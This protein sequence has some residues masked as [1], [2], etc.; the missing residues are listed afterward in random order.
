VLGGLCG[1]SSFIAGPGH[2]THV[3]TA[4]YLAFGE[5]ENQISERIQKLQEVF[6][7][8]DGM[9]VV[10]P[11]D[12]HFAMWEKFVFICSV[13]G[14]GAVTRQPFGSFRAVSESRAMLRASI[15]EAAQ[16]GRARG[17]NLPS[18]MVNAILKRIDGLPGA[19]VAS[20][21]K[22]I[23]EGRPSEL[24]AQTGAV[25]RMGRILGVPTPTHEFIYASLL[26]M[27][28]KARGK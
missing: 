21:Q 15:E 2:I 7:A 1:I 17:V 11:E 24:E 23:M 9:N 10:V 12:I 27:E 14:V 19:M 8:L 26:P 6:S 3:A 13:S 4:P 5:L 18:D 28:L 25:V 16:V 20:M 22:D